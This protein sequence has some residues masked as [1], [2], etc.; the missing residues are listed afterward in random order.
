MGKKIVKII[1]IVDKNSNNDLDKTLYSVTSDKYKNFKPI[2]FIKEGLEIDTD[3][4]I[5]NIYY[6]DEK[7]IYNK[8]K[9]IEADYI[10]FLKVGDS[11][12]TNF[13]EKVNRRIEKEDKII[14]F[15]VNEKYR[16]NNKENGIVRIEDKPYALAIHLYGNVI[17]KDIFNQIKIDDIDFKYDL[18]INIFTKMLMIVG[19]LYK[20][21]KIKFKP[22]ETYDDIIMDKLVYYY[23]DWYFDIFKNINS[24]VK[25]SLS[26]YDNVIKYTQ[27]IIMYMLKIRIEVNVNVKNKHILNDKEYK[28][29]CSLMCEVLKYVD[30]KI[31]MET[32][33]NKNINYYMLKTKYDR[34][35]SDK[36]REYLREIYVE[37]EN[38]KIMSASETKLKIILLDILDDKLIIYGMYPF[39]IKDDMN[40]IA[41]S[42]DKEYFAEKI[43][44]YSKYKSFNHTLYESYAFKLEVNIEFERNQTIGLY[45]IKGD[46]K[47]KLRA[48]FTKPMSKLNNNEFSYWVNGRYIINYRNN[49]IK[50]IKNSA[51][52]HIK[53]ELLY[54]KNL[55]KNKATKRSAYL[56]MI[57]WITK[58]L[59]R[60]KMW[61]FVDKI[62]KAGDNGE[63]LYKYSLKQKD[64]IKKY[65]VLH[66]NCID[67][68]RF[69]KEKIKFLKYGSIFQ[70]LVFL[71]SDV[72]FLTHNNAVSSY[73]FGKEEEA[74]FRDL[75]NYKSVCIQHGLTVQYMPHLT[76]RINDNLKLYFLASEVEK[77][78]ILEDEYMFKDAKDV[79][80]VTGCPRYDGLKNKSDK[81]ILITPSWRNYL[82]IPSNQKGEKRGYNNNFKESDYYKIY[83]N[84]IN[85]KEL[86]EKARK[87][88]YRIVYL[89]HPVTSSQIDDYDRNEYVEL[90]AATDNLNYEKILTESSLMVT[91]YSGVQF[92]FAY[93]YKPI[94]Y[95]HPKE[96]PPSYDEGEYKYSTMALGEIVET[97]K[98]L[99]DSLCDYMDNECRI[100][101]EY[102]NRID[103]FFKY[104][105]FNNC[106]RIYNEV[107]KK[108]YEKK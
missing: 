72:A 4:D 73:S 53:R 45:L 47:V 27:Y 85:N 41:I 82:S 3:C 88:S 96:L 101:E 83:N 54:I 59:F 7:D 61:V 21:D 32:K 38:D 64:R 66:E 48:N 78:N 2:L 6:K 50:I 98:Q 43:P 28:K 18:D 36:Y 24:M 108:F 49:R 70:R 52:R 90:I 107:M 69:K 68:K 9:L 29:F 22:V 25:F 97:E 16:F 103:K 81:I 95:F 106:E 5:E 58:P 11:Y 19:E 67:A 92:D 79:L 20:I 71:N 17:N 93:M 77:Y 94:I 46:S 102:K 56:R 87:K 99:V 76:N 39:P 51:K 86:I 62:Y 104:H 63:Y 34:L 91:D 30:N 75:Y 89:L 40:I 35:S 84:L 37:F 13:C 33:G 10:T 55:L 44:L 105:D 57:Y 14:A 74:Y 26:R 65:Y 31:I 12:S 42:N 8:A 100:K 60:N 23:L 15:N 1:V 80:K